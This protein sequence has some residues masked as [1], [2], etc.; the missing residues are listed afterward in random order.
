MSIEVPGPSGKAKYYGAAITAYTIWGF[1]SLVLRPLDAYTAADI[2]FYRVFSCA[3][4]MLLIVFLFR[5]KKWTETVQLFKSLPTDKKRLTILLNI[6]GSIFLTG[7]WFSFIY[8]MNHISIKAT[9]LAYMV[10]PILTTLL[11]F[12]ILH[13]KLNR[14]QWLAVALSVTGC[15][16]LSYSDLRDMYFSLIVGFSYACYLVSQR[17]NA[18]FDT[19]IV[20]TFHIVLSSI[21]LLPFFFAYSGKLPSAYSFYAF[22][23]IIAVFFTIIP[24]FLNL[25]ALTGINS[26]V[27]GMLLN[28]NPIIAFTLATWVFHEQINPVQIISYSIILIAV[29]VFN[30]KEIFMRK[31]GISK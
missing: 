27:V 18:G 23:G 5:R 21:I 13:E 11:A 31:E 12:F 19:F 20:L 9:S 4:L 1:F 28:I 24:L 16:L 7:N 2:L 29:I 22:I 10:C 25:Y 15:L 3:V 30:G 8:V 14:L 6:G 26:S 17:R